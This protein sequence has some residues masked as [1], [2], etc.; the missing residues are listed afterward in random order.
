[1]LLCCVHVCVKVALLC[2]TC[3]YGPGAAVGE[4]VPLPVCFKVNHLH[5]PH[6]G[7]ETILGKNSGQLPQFL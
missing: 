1:M 4:A 7:C 5:L 6:L 2:D 3:G